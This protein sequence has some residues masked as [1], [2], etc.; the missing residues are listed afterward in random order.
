VAVYLQDKNQLISK[1]SET[2]SETIQKLK[3]QVEN[4]NLMI[5]EIMSRRE[6][7]IIALAF[8]AAKTGV[9]KKDVECMLQHEREFFETITKKISDNETTLKEFLNGKKEK[10]L[11]NQLVRFKQD[12]DEFVDIDG[13]TLGPFKAGDVANLPKE[14]INILNGEGKTEIIIQE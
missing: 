11:K 6:K 5:H 10:S 3:K 2:F 13:N 12:V 1:D 9:S 7:K 14:M 8:L 4:V